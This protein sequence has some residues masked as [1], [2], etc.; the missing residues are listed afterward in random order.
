MQNSSGDSASPWYMLHL[1]VTCAM[2][3]ELVSSVVFHS[4]IE[5]LRNAIS[6]L[7]AL[8]CAKHSSIHVWGIES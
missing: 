8:Y 7:L 3:L 1:M 4:C 5:F 6:V 2:G